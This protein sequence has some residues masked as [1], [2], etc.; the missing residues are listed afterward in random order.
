MAA[1]EKITQD[2]DILSVPKGYEIPFVSLPFQEKIPNLTKISKQQFLLVEQEV[3]EMLEKEAIQKVVAKQFLNNLFFVEKQDG[4]NG[5]V[6]NLKNINKFIPYEHCKM[7]GLQFLKFL[8]KQ[9]DFLCKTDLKEA[10]FS[11]PLNKNSQ[12]FV[13]FQW[14]GYIYEFFCLCFGLGPAPI[15]FTKLLKVPIALLRRVNI[16]IIFYIYDML[17]MRRTLPEIFLAK[18]YCN[19]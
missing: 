5:P 15:I 16:R 6:M 3:L 11:V 12:T 4:G 13:R 8:L 18:D 19:I 1:W 7:E 10:Y 9:D 14:S 2:E 17:L